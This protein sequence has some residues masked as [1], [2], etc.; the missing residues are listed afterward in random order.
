MTRKQICSDR[1]S[2]DPLVREESLLRKLGFRANNFQKR[3]KY[4]HGEISKERY[5]NDPKVM[6]AG[7]TF[8]DIK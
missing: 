7:E 6:L 4:F 1:F 8:D 5:G 3:W 2:S